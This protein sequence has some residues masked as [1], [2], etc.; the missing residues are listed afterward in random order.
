MNEQ[1]E[2]EIKEFIINELD[3]LASSFPCARFRYE[4][5]ELADVH[6]VEASPNELYHNNNKYIAREKDLT[7]RFIEL[8]PDQ[9]ICFIPDDDI[10]GI[11]RVDY[12]ISGCENKS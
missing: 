5:D 6:V 4:Y 9:N 8:F 12:E 2:K 11:S 3:E 10:V 7:D 1:L